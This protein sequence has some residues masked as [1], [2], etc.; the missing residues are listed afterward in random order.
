ME[1]RCLELCTFVVEES[2]NVLEGGELP[3]RKKPTEAEI[4]DE[5]CKAAKRRFLS[6]PGSRKD[7]SSCPIDQRP[8]LRTWHI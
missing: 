6:A 3:P 7:D 2:S 1:K 4:E 8:Y 5:R